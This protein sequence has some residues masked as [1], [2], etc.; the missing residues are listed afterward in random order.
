MINDALLSGAAGDVNSPAAGL[1]VTEVV[2]SL[3]IK[4]DATIPQPLPTD[5]EI[6]ITDSEGIK[7]VVGESLEMKIGEVKFLELR[8]EPFISNLPYVTYESSN[9]RVARFIEDG[10]ILACCPGTIKVT[11]TTSEDINN[12]Q[13]ATMIITVVDPNT[14]KTK[15][16]KK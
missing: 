13:V 12:P 4:K 9:L 14:T 6:N 8:Q 10:V 1:P 11:A 7:F 3:D 5:K 2:K 15:K 16:G